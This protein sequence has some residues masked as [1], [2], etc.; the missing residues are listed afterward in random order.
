MDQK[1]HLPCIRLWDKQ[2]S[3]ELQIQNLL[4]E[5]NKENDELNER[6]FSQEDPYKFYIDTLEFENRQQLKLRII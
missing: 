2:R 1:L 3:R 6:Y 4:I 5:F